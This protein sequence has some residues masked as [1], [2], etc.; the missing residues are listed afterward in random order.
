MGFGWHQ[1]NQNNQVRAVI[2]RYLFILVFMPILL[3][4]SANDGDKFIGKWANVQRPQYVLNIT[5]NGENYLVS[6]SMPDANCLNDDRKNPAEKAK[7]APFKNPPINAQYKDGLLRAGMW[8]YDISKS[9]GN[10]IGNG[11]EYKLM[12]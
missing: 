11:H 1:P 8:T 9:T 5:K 12:K 3:G 4:C 2:R 7:C 6:L 10:M